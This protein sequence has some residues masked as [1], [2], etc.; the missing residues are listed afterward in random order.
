[1]PWCSRETGADVP[2]Q[3]QAVTA[4][5]SS[6]CSVQRVETWRLSAGTGGS[7]GQLRRPC[8]SEGV[9]GW[10]GG[11]DERRRA[12]GAAGGRNVV[13]RHR[14]GLSD[15]GE[16]QEGERSDGEHY[17]QGERRKRRR[18]KREREAGG[19]KG[20]EPARRVH[21]GFEGRAWRGSERKHARS[22][23]PARRPRG[24]FWLSAGTPDTNTPDEAESRPPRRGRRRS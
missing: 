16:G 15:G 9:G 21:A 12:V 20:G 18:G 23:D 24:S 14:R 10:S 8:C 2:L 19:R 11:G 6:Y 13:R 7:K 1:L 17:R 3:K 5:E 4:D 22:L